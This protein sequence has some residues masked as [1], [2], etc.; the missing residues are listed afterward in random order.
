MKN[1]G[2]ADSTLNGGCVK[3]SGTHTQMS[4]DIHCIFIATVIRSSDEEPAE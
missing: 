4:Q 2:L 1:K 3:T